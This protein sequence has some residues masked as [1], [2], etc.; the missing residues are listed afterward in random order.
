VTREEMDAAIAAIDSYVERFPQ[1][2]VAAL[3]EARAW[4]EYGYE[5][6]HAMCEARGWTRRNVLTAPERRPEVAAL[7]QAG[8]STRA[9]AAAV[10][11]SDKTIRNDLDEL[12]TTTQLPDEITSLDGRT[13]PATRPEVITAEEFVERYEA[14]S[15]TTPDLDDLIPADL[16]FQRRFWR[17]MKTTHDL[18]LDMDFPQ[19]FDEDMAAGLVR[20]V[21]TIARK[22]TE[23]AKSRRTLRVVQGG[24]P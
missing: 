20:F 8:M 23:F 5:S 4:I 17:H 21:D 12:R 16:R 1:E 3:W 14:D 19:Y 13:R 6:W 9:I 2:L 18:L 24:N 22:H 15:E 11:V 7:R 10:G